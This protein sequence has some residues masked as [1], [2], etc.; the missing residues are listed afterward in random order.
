M[1]LTGATPNMNCLR[2]RV[3]TCARK[4]SHGQFICDENFCWT[5]VNCGSGDFILLIVRFP[6][7]GDKLVIIFVLNVFSKYILGHSAS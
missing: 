3:L 2:S 7:T 1:Q 6:K 5:A 4:C